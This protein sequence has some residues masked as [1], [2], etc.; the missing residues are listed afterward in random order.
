MCFVV[1]SCLLFVV[2]AVCGLFVV[3]CCSLWCH[4]FSLV[5]CRL[6]LLYGDV[7][8]CC[9]SLVVRCRWVLFV[10]VCV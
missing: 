10:V 5:V 2:G 3:C 7:D 4:C 8:V 6:L 9:L 1:V